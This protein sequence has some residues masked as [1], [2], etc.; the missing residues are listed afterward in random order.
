MTDS[1]AMSGTE[2]IDKEFYFL[3]KCF[4]DRFQCDF[5]FYRS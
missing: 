3:I 2:A 1:I 5:L 4:S